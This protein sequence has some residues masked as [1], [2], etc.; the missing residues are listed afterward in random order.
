M[1]RLDPPTVLLDPTFIAA[2]VDHDEPFHADAVAEYA[3]MLDEYER[4]QILLTATSDALAGMTPSVRASLF[5]PVQE[6]RIAEQHRNASLDVYGASRE[7]PDFAT[8]LV[9]VHREG[10][11]TVAS[12]D[13]RLDG[14]DVR[15]RPVRRPPPSAEAEPADR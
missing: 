6:L 10:V 7:D 2:L 3:T 11:D 15:V 5:A 9:I 4:E 13:T 14:L 8:M 12:F 1:G